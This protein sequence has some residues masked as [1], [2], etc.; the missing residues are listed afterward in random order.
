M[1]KVLLVDDTAR[2][3]IVWVLAQLARGEVPPQIRDLMLR[4]QALAQEKENGERQSAI[5]APIHK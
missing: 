4:G 5:I 2:K 3:S 1:L